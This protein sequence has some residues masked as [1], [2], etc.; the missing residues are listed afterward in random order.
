MEFDD[1]WVCEDGFVKGA[2]ELFEEMK[3]D[4]FEPDE[5]TV[6]RVLREGVWGYWEFGVGEGG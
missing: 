1:F 2:L 5:M 6:V 4:G 3:R